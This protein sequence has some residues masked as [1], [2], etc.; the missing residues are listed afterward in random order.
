[1]RKVIYE[2]NDIEFVQYGNGTIYAERQFNNV[3]V[4][5]EITQLLQ[6]ARKLGIYGNWKLCST[7]KR[8]ILQN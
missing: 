1:M 7:F 5:I 2:Q 6:T 3:Y 8:W 4:E